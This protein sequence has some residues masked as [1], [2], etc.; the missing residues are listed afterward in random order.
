LRWWLSSKKFKAAI[1]ATICKAALEFM[2]AI[3]SGGRLSD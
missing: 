3:E 1:T 2:I